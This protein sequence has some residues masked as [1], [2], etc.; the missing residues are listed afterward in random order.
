MSK[1]T[2]PVIVGAARTPVGRFLGGLSPLPA[3]QLGAIAVREA[4]ARS[5]VDA[6]AVDEIMR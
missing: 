2:T 3:T 4:V 6:T 5:G 1:D